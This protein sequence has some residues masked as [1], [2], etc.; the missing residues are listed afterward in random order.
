M[1]NQLTFLLYLFYLA[2][3]QHF[4]FSKIKVSSYYILLT[5]H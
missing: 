5:H 4:M 3:Y 1:T 2:Y